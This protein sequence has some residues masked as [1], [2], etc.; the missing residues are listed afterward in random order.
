MRRRGRTAARLG[1]RPAAS[2]ICVRGNRAVAPVD[3]PPSSG[4]RRLGA[5]AGAVVAV[6]RDRD[7]RPARVASAERFAGTVQRWIALL[8]Q[9]ADEL[10]LMVRACAA[11]REPPPTYAAKAT[12]LLDRARELVAPLRV[13][14]C[15]GP[16]HSTDRL[17]PYARSRWAPTPATTASP[18]STRASCTSSDPRRP[19]TWARSRCS[20][21][22]RSTTPTAGS[23]STT[24]AALVASRLQLIPRFRKRVMPVPFGRG[25][26][27]WVDHDGFD[28]ADHVRPDHA[29]GARAIGVSCFELAERLMAPGARPRAGRCGSCGS[30]RASTAASTSGSIHK[31]HHTLTDG[32]SGVDIATVLLDFAREP[33]VLDPDGW[34]PAPPPD[35]TR[36]VI[37][38]VAT[39]FT[40]PA[41]LAGQCARRGRRVLVMRRPR[42]GLGRSI[43]SLVGGQVR[44]PR[45][46]R[47]TAPVGGPPDRDRAASRSTPCAQSGRSS[48]AR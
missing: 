18:R 30:S 29:A 14:S 23:A 43:G 8:D 22:R 1:I 20:S 40:R 35:P 24:C 17:T 9:G 45:A 12:T 11:D 37:D 38:T 31:S 32:I 26:P 15:R 28:I 33:T 44:A 27:V 39:R 41:E 48:G 25:R 10:E 6:Q 47:S 3:V 16:V 4:R 5:G 34:T 42:P 46:C 7:R 2:A 21:A 13:T 36:L 19:C